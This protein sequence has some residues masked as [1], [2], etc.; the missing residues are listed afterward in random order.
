MTDPAL[1]EFKPGLN[2]HIRVAFDMMRERQVRI[3]P[4]CGRLAV[5]DG[6]IIRDGVAIRDGGSLCR[7]TPPML[8]RRWRGP[9]TGRRQPVVIGEP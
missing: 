6:R 5:R 9:A 3:P 1:R 4:L 8:P 7:R 2:H